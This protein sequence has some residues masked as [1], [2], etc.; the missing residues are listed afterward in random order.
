MSEKDFLARLREHQG[1][2]YKLVHLYADTEE[3]KKDLYQE[4]LLQAWKSY[5]GF[6]GESLNSV[7]GSTVCA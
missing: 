4:I 6:R 1:I 7:P 3:D 2:V 5:P